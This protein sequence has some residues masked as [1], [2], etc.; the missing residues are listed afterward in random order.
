MQTVEEIVL[1]GVDGTALQAKM[2]LPENPK[3]LVVLLHAPGGSRHDK[4]VKR[5]ARELSGLNIG[6]LIPDLT[7][8]TEGWH[9]VRDEPFLVHRAA[10]V[11]MWFLQKTGRKEAALYACGASESFITALFE[12]APV[13]CAAVQTAEGVKRHRPGQT[14][15]PLGLSADIM[16]C[17]ED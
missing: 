2:V 8:E 5:I 4:P 17:F 3:G 14:P 11:V 1:I 10:A 13:V 12:R 7:D 15:E 6:L 9:G 16:V